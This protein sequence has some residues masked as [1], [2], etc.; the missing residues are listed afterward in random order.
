MAL[1]IMQESYSSTVILPMT[2]INLYRDKNHL[3]FWSQEFD[4]PMKLEGMLMD[5]FCL[6]PSDNVPLANDAQV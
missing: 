6:F 1:I 3:R 2:S 5:T 4:N